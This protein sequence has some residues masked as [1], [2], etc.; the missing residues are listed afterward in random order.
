VQYQL[1]VNTVH[2]LEQTWAWAVCVLD[3]AERQLQQ[4]QNFDV[5]VREG[6]RKEAWEGVRKEAWEG[7]RV[8]GR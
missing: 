6:G 7:V 2:T 5:Q 3:M 1:V 8:I 4:G